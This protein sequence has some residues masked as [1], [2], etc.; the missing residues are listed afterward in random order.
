MSSLPTVFVSHGPPTL[1]LERHPVVDFLRGAAAGWPQPKA[2]LCVSAH[3][4][5]EAPAIS[6]ASAPATVHDFYGFP[7][8]L[9]RL[10]YPAPGAP[11]LAARVAR[12][13]TDDGLPCTRDPAQGL[14]HGAWVPLLLMYPAA[15][16]PVAQL[17]IQH[18]LGP[19][20]HL[21]L[22]RALAP[23]RG[24]GILILASGNTTHNL[25]D[26]LQHLRGPSAAPPAPP[27]WALAFDA[28]VNAA[29]E[30]GDHAALA[31][32][33]AQAPHAAMAHPRD[34]HFLP[35]LVAAGA[36]GRGRVLHTSFML[37]SLSMGAYAFE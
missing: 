4:E 22:G 19:H 21:A 16:V 10:R 37:G 12:L 30:R 2:I 28:W 20:H 33:R 1:A 9:Y 31:D 11:D 34:E 13:L 36:G 15:A 23:L 7:E 8:P 3:W 27:P 6:G 17:A 25:R 29:V 35:L 14:D 26:A 24:E 18:R 5:T 32:Y